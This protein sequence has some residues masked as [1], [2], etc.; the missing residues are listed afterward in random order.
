[1]S[2]SID[3]DSGE[4][5]ESP[6]VVLSGWLNDYSAG[7]CDRADMQTS[8]LEICRSNSEAPWDALALLDQYQ[9]RGRIDAALARTLKADIA[10]LVFGASNQTEGPREPAKDADPS[11]TQGRTKRSV[12]KRPLLPQRS[13]RKR[14]SPNPRF[15]DALTSIH[16]HGRPHGCRSRRRS[17]HS[18]NPFLPSVALRPRP[19][20]G[21]FSGNVTSYWRSSARAK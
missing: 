2:V 17:R 4:S 5:G 1:M 18:R 10:Q 11:M 16:R 19:R 3:K 12:R 8:F 6:R 15:S 14:S 13:G 9:R 7:R 20:R 21:W